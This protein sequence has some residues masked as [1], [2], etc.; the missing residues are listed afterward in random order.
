[1]HLSLVSGFQSVGT[2]LEFVDDVQKIQQR[3]RDTATSQLVHPSTAVQALWLSLFS[4]CIYLSRL[5]S[6]PYRLLNIEY[7]TLVN[8]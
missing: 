1:M 7:H 4:C 6:E 5:A 8:H 3:A 2:V